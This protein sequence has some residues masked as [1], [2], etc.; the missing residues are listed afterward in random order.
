MPKV[1]YEVSKES[2]HL[3]ST[4]FYNKLH[5]HGYFDLFMQVQTLNNIEGSKLNW[6]QRELWKVCDSAWDILKKKKIPPMLVFLHPKVLQL[7]PSF[8][9]YYRSIA[10]LPQKG[11]KIISGVTSVDNIELGKISPGTLKKEVIDSLTTSINE[12]MSLV[13]SLST[14]INETEIQGMMYATAGT[15]IDGSWRNSIGNEGERVIRSIIL[16]EL[17]SQGDVSSITDK[18]NKTI[19]ITALKPSDILDGVD[20]IRIVNFVN[21]FSILFGSEPD[22]TLIDDSSAVVGVIEVKAGLD[23]AGALERLGAMFKSFDNTLAEYPNAITILVASCITDEVESRIGAAMSV[24]QRYITTD[25]TSS[26]SNQRKFANR[27]RRILK[28]TT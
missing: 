11:L 23:P 2:Y 8:L 4:F 26:D 16:R 27:V 15:Y 22:I 17:L 5:S 18:Q 21:G 24:R 3:K 9:K 13:V 19:S 14:D 6:S 7:H 25:I 10:M 1:P 28:L 12:V 20:N